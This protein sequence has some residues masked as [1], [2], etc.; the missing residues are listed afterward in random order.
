MADLAITAANVV[1]GADAVVEDGWFGEAVTQGQAVY[2]A[3]DGKYYKADCDS[4]T[5]AVR[6]PRGLALNAGSANQ[7]A[8]VQTKGKITIGATLTAGLAY[9]LS[10]TAGG[11]CPVADIAAG[12]YATIIG[13]ATS[14]T[15]L[16][17]NITESGVAV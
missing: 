2:R 5:A 3:S 9:Y 1:Q 14:T 13:I 4:A 6:S 17:I 7:P 11:L 15:E 12:G 10:K 16:K 8:R